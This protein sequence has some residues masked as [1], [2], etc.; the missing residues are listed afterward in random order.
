MFQ[1][2]DKIENHIGDVD[3]LIK[4]LQIECDK[5]G[6]LIQEDE[7]GNVIYFR[8]NEGK[9][10]LREYNE[11]NLRTKLTIKESETDDNPLIITY[12]YDEFN[13]IIREEDNK[14]NLKEMSYDSNKNIIKEII[15]KDNE[16]IY[17]GSYEYDEKGNIIYQEDEKIG[18]KY[19]YINDDK[20][21]Y[22]I[23]SYNKEFDVYELTYN[24][25]KNGYKKF[26]IRGNG[27]R[28]WL[29]NGSEIHKE[30]IL[31]PIQNEKVK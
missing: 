6:I 22:C 19:I 1:F 23:V 7:R 31:Q 29:F 8:N 5:Y 17:N 28:V 24:N 2:K 26:E 27:D 15:K 16:I 30:N 4:E 11:K 9:I 20:F 25:Y 14:G 3:E 18:K 12:E 21:L 10:E 13:N